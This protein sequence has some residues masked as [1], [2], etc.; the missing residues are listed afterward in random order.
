[1]QIE[2][3]PG[4]GDRGHSVYQG[5]VSVLAPLLHPVEFFVEGTSAVAAW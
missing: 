2:G 1:M 5:R 3:C 4:L